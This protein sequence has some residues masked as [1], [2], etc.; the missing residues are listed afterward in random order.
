VKFNGS[1]T[2]QVHTLRV[3]ADR[4]VSSSLEAALPVAE[5]DALWF[6][7]EG[8][9]EI[10]VGSGAELAQNSRLEALDNAQ[11]WAAVAARGPVLFDEYH[12]LASAA[13]TTPRSVWAVGLQFVLCALVFVAVFGARL[14]PPRPQAR[15]LH[16][17]GIEYV[18]AMARLLHRARVE[19]EL[20]V[21]VQQQMRAL[22]H[23][24]LG[25]PESLSWADAALEVQAHFASAAQAFAQVGA[26]QNLVQAS[27]AAAQF[28][29]ALLGL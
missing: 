17:A 22:A 18:Q 6:I 7:T 15:R 4:H 8:A 16:R 12:H 27:T 21:S 2:T 5:Y 20:L 13:V 3:A 24:R 23:E 29:R 1:L 10:W 26:S 11:F 14:G 28:E 9:G 19:P 25:I